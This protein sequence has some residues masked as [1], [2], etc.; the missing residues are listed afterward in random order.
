MTID[1][2]HL[3]LPLLLALAAC[4]GADSESA[5]TANET[6]FADV[7]EEPAQ[8][9]ASSSDVALSRGVESGAPP[10]ARVRGNGE[11]VAEVQVLAD[12]AV[13]TTTGARMDPSLPVAPGS[14][15]LDPMI[16]RTGTANVQVDSLDRGIAQVRALAARVGGI[17]GNTSISGG[18]DQERHASIELRVPSQNFDAALTGLQPIGKVQNVNVTA[19]DVGEEYAD[20][21]ARVANAR[22][23]ESRLLDLLDRRTGRLEEIL[24]LEREV[25]RVREEIERYEGRLRYL[26]T[27]ASIS[28]LTITLHEPNAVI[29]TPRG[30]RPIRDAFGIAWRNFVGLIAGLIAATG[31]LIPLAI[32]LYGAWRAWRWFRRR[33]AER[34]AIY[35]E[36]IRRARASAPDEPAHLP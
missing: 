27:R 17:I 5:G 3:V 18:T 36:N 4:G 35:R 2:K 25:A 22:R 6:V 32:V 10:V 34:D 21:T 26:R 28:T 7:Q 14:V 23:L 1:R 13:T 12:P 19:Q 29:G 16:I 11:Q 30:E 15:S 24:N 33:E 31:L 20:V 9:A 8:G